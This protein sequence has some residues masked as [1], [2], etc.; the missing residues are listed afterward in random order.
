MQARR[1]KTMTNSEAV[2]LL[3]DRFPELGN[4]SLSDDEPYYAYGLLGSEIQARKN[5]PVFIEVVCKFVTELANSR[6]PLLKDILITCVLERIAEDP[7]LASTIKA[8]LDG[9]TKVL[10]ENVERDLF[11]RK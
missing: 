2:L 5:N 7:E 4:E 9:A 3:L 1:V 8:R 10:L 11:G 6:D